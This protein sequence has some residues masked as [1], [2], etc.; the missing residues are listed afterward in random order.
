MNHQNIPILRREAKNA[1][2][3]SR[4]IASDYATSTSGTT[5]ITD[6]PI[7]TDSSISASTT[8]TSDTTAADTDPGDSQSHHLNATAME[9]M[10]SSL[11]RT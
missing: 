9:D 3:A 4:T 2:S 11:N 6:D 8:P 1:T 7:G 5:N 10:P